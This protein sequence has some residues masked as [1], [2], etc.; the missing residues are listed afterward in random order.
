MNISANL[1]GLGPLIGYGIQ[2]YLI[3]LISKKYD[4]FKISLF[5]Q[6]FGFILTLL[7]FPFIN[8]NIFNFPLFLKMSLSGLLF[9]LGSITFIYGLKEGTASIVTPI[10]S[11]KAVITAIL[12]FIF[13]KEKI[14][15]IK[16]LGILTTFSGIIFVST[17]FKN[18]HSAKKINLEKGFKWAILTAILWGT[19]LFFFSTSSKESHW[20][21]S[22]LYLRLW[23]TITFIILY[24][25]F[26]TNKKFVFNKK[27]FKILLLA[28]IFDTMANITLSMG[29][30]Y[31]DIS[32][33]SVLS[34]GSS[35]VTVICSLIF[36]KE[37]LSFNQII[38]ILLTIAGIIILSVI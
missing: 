6:L 13:L 33:V 31:G 18:L 22:N 17:D 32:V 36:L 38:G 8:V 10:A 5:L 4:T 1:Y 34:N 37:K 28:S 26:K 35:V 7:L 11:S 9:S 14:L 30:I 24:P 19:G 20:F 15:L 29:F 3:A 23:T 2:N 21:T 12:S 25:L 16:I 27:F